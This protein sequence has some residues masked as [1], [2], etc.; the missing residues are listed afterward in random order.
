MDLSFNDFA[1]WMVWRVP[2]LTSA[3]R[4]PQFD[5]IFA[6]DDMAGDAQKRHRTA[7]DICVSNWHMS[8][9]ARSRRIALYAAAQPSAAV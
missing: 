6:L 2:C 1:G 5:A 9:C 3:L 4:R 7:T 8:A